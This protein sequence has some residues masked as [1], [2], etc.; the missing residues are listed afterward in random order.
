MLGVSLQGQ[1]ERRAGLCGVP[2]G[3]M[4]A[5]EIV[6]QLSVRRTQPHGGLELRQRCGGFAPQQQHAT[7]RG[8]GGHVPGVERDGLSQSIRRV[9]QSAGRG[10]CRTQPEMHFSAARRGCRSL[11]QRRDGRI[12]LHQ[13]ELHLGQPQTRI[14]QR[15]TLLDGEPEVLLGGLRLPDG[16]VDAPEP[17][18]GDAAPRLAARLMRDRVL[19]ERQRIAPNLSIPPRLRPEP[20]DE[21]ERPDK[22][23][24]GPDAAGVVGPLL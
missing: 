24:A 8:V 22:Q 15:R 1:F 18:E 14:S 23:R 11:A 7:Q 6:V 3:A 10:E 21:G 16:R 13:L 12:S 5:P 17:I 2:H 20:N 4:G 19:P 9:V